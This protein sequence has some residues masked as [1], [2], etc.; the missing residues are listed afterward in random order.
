M[1]PTTRRKNR[2]E[3]SDLAWG[4]SANTRHPDPSVFR[5]ISRKFG[6]LYQWRIQFHSNL[7]GVDRSHENSF[8]ATT[9]KERPEH[10][11]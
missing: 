3:E 7:K 10:H 6:W 2:A 4:S 5:S 11:Y 9:A 8:V 1:P